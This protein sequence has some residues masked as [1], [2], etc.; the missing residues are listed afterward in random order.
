MP[1]RLTQTNFTPLVDMRYTTVAG[2]A[3]DTLKIHSLTLIFGARFEHLGP[4]TDRHNNGLATFSDSLYKSQCG[5]YTR[6]CTSC[7][8]PGH[9]VGFAEDRR[10]ELRQFSADDLCN[11]SRGGIL[12]HLWQRQDRT[13]R[14][15]GHVP[16]PGAVQSLRPGGGHGPGIQDLEPAGSA[17]L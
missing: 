10:V 11:S 5:G 16:Q 8:L 9:H 1:T 15:L 3:M 4:W 6:N 14:R 13:A 17:D 12:G 7:R 2:F